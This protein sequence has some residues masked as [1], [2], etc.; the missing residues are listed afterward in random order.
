M[1]QSE[2]RDLK[3]TQPKAAVF[4]GWPIWNQLTARLHSWRGRERLDAAKVRPGENR[5]AVAAEARAVWHHLFDTV[6]DWLKQVR[7]QIDGKTIGKGASDQK[8]TSQRELG[9]WTPGQGSAEDKR[10]ARSSEASHPAV[11]SQTRAQAQA[12]RQTEHRVKPAFRTWFAW[13]L[14]V[15]LI[16]LGLWLIWLRQTQDRLYQA[17]I[18]LVPT[19]ASLV[20]GWQALSGEALNL[21]RA[22]LLKAA[23]EAHRQENYPVAVI[24]LTTLHQT[25]PLYRDTLLAEAQS[26]VGL[27]NRLVELDRK[28]DGLNPSRRAKLEAAAAESETAGLVAQFGQP[29]YL[30]EQALAALELGLR[31]DPLDRR[32]IEL[33]DAI[34]NL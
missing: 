32:L 12:K 25:E 33:K 5:P 20:E 6:Q 10:S 13:A 1:S 21:P 34:I 23:A 15:P 30:L 28:L 8:A 24:Y 2:G 16:I 31:L 7:A 11:H 4:H 14:I 19:T 29:T 3:P 9:Q 27:Y 18:D 17:E 26:Y 22:E